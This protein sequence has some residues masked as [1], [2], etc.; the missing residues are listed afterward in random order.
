MYSQI[1]YSLL[2]NL[3]FNSFPCVY[4]LTSFVFV[5]YKNIG[6]CDLFLLQMFV[7]LMHLFSLVYR[8]AT[9]PQIYYKFTIL[10]A[11]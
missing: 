1:Y 7:R 10:L 11:I 9:L 6:L 2:T 5:F 4:P 8:V 3:Y